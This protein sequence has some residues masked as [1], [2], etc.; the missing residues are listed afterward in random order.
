MRRLLA[1]AAT[2]LLLLT[3]LALANPA[4]AAAGVRIM[5][6]G[7]SITDGF[8]VPGGYRID[9][10]PKL[11]AA[12]YQVDFVGSQS[13]GPAA[14][15]DREHEG[16]SGWRIDQIDANIVSW[17]RTYTP[18]TVLLH[19][20]TNDII[21]N[22]G[23]A[24]TRL[25]NLVDRITATAPEARVFVA[26]IVP[27]PSSASAVSAYNATIP[28]MV[29]A[30]ANAGKHVYLVDMF[31]ALGANDLA[32]GV[33]PNAGGY[34]KM[35]TA[36]YN[37]LRAVPDSLTPG[38]SAP[39]SSAPASSRPPSSAPASSPP[40]S[41]SPG[42]GGA[43]TASVRVVNSWG[44]GFQAEATVRNTGGAT[45]TAW[46]ARLTLANGQSITNLWGGTPSASTG[47]VNVRNAGYNGTIAPNGSTT[48]G[49]VANG[50]GSTAPA[51]TGCTSP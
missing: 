1:A 36:W 20:G 18:R 2:G 6:L 23:G 43:C 34:A 11:T 48:F 15:T 7:D 40:P 24:S 27:L 32:D 50:D 38:A 39:P 12:G 28:G 10:L 31:G 37:A 42:T 49:F 47:A 44:G 3:G 45:I 46:T 41:S 13:N 30:R 26:T 9:L 14:L 17:L 21:Q 5:P 51:V 35:A 4:T 16:H 22:A 19:I 29:Q 25:A 8:N 33:H